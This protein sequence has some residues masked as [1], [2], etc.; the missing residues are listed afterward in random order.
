MAKRKI[1]DDTPEGGWL[2]P[3]TP[4]LD[5]T[6]TPS[7]ER[8]ATHYADGVDRKGRWVWKPIGPHHLAR[9]RRREKDVS[10]MP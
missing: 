6:D 10:K 1:I 8:V 3:S 4:S 2:G 7:C 5:P 9:V